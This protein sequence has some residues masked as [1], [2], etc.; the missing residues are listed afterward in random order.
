DN[1]GVAGVWY[2]LNYANYLT[3]EIGPPFQYNWDTTT[4][5]DGQYVL[6]MA[7]ANAANRTAETPAIIVNVNNNS[8][9]GWNP[10]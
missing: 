9:P 5:P 7:A 8:G 3:G 6:Q 10:F 2:V 4:V 1:V